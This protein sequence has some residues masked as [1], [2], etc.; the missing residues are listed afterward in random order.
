MAGWDWLAWE[1]ER[2]GLIKYSNIKWECW[3]ADADNLWINTGGSGSSLNCTY[4]FILNFAGEK[5]NVKENII[6]GGEG[7]ERFFC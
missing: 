4:T 7:K 3:D 2:G 5:K 1:T 6:G